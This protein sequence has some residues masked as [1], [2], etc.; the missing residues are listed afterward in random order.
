[1]LKKLNEVLPELLLGIFLYGIFVQL[2]GIWVVEDKIQYTIGLW[3]GIILAMGMAI[4]IALVI[5]DAVDYS[6]SQ[7]KLVTMSL[8]RYLV[9]VLVFAGMIYFHIGNPIVG[10]IGV[11]G[12]KIGA[13]MQPFLHKAIIKLQEK[14]SHKRDEIT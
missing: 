2:I 13:Y 4:H 11:M 12:L 6:G 8:L 1:M 3:I 9:V 14:S 5:R 7:G 10:F